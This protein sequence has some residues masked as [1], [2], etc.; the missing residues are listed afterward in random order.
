MDLAIAWA[1][2]PL[3]LTAV[4]AGCGLLVERLIRTKIPG[5]LIPVLGFATVIVV[6]QLVTL[7]DATARLATPV[8]VILAV[9][10][11]A[12]SWGWWRRLEP[13]AVAVA[14]GVFAAYAAPIVLSGQATFAGYIR[15][16][17]TATWMALTDRVMEH[18]RSLSGLA[19]STYEATLAFNLG[20][21][22]PVGAFLPLGIGRALVGQ[23]VAWLIQPYMAW[24]AGAASLALW[25]LASPVVRSRALR[26]LVSFL[27]ALSALLLGY[28]LW[29]GVKEVA[30]AALVA[31][32]AGLTGAAI[33]DR[34][35]VRALIPLALVSA[36]LIGVLS[37]G[38]G[39]WLAGLLV[40]ALPFAA[41]A[42]G[43]RRALGRATALVALIGLLCVPV[44]AP[45][46]FL[47]PT[48]A[49][50]SSETALGNLLHPLD[51][52]Q[53]FGIWPAGDFRLNPVNPGATYALIGATGVAALVGLYT[54]WRRRASTVLIYVGGALAACLAIILIGSPW[55]AGKAMATAS[56]AALMA[57][58]AG[59]AAL[60]TGGRGRTRLVGR[61]VGATLLAAIG[62]G[63]LWSGALAYRDLNLAPRNQLVELETIGHRIAGEGPTLMTEYQPYGVRHFLRDADPEGASELRRR[64]VPLLGGGTL[65]KGTSAD[66]DR[67][68]LSGLLV[69][70]TLVLRRSP[71]QSRPP[72]PY[73]LTWRGRYYEVWQRPEGLVS[74]VIDHLGLGTA[75][76]PTGE[77]KCSDVLRLAREAGP[78]GTL[79]AARRAAVEAVPLR[80]TSHPAA[81]RWAG[82]PATLLPVTPGTIRS[83]VR[84]SRPGR[85]EVWLGGSV[86]PRVDLLVDGRQ[87]GEVRHD[88]NNA[89]QFVLLGQTRLRAGAHELSI[90]F[91]GADLHPG[92]G[93]S[94]SPIGPLELSA[95]DPA[96]DRLTRVRAGRA[97]TLCGERLDW[98]EALAPGG[99]GGD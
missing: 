2:F 94:V 27:A 65:A 46:G 79:V 58:G 21:G 71:A 34:L 20:S 38:G 45:G 32:A 60:W 23:D 75:Q 47:P 35:S 68:R 16:D 77:P 73:R 17:D 9:A 28:Y 62:V 57:A 12:L 61:A 19:P 6:A 82:Y 66:T 36:A 56:P 5:A 26:S 8:A 86:R 51:A 88:L 93:G 97:T 22:Y 84:V 52:L 98:I 90:R 7:W 67:F 70:R 44:L 92:S 95:T 63:V 41:R 42:V 14:V 3:V 33:R 43:V 76:D 89:G 80:R 69:Y 50:L 1:L 72:S 40:A 78:S 29:G 91:H 48:S 31:A 99:L 30:G 74:S 37:G 81:W 10:G 25:E 49:S 4:C 18:G 96:Q 85:Y 64:Q 87:V 59:A 54:A 15:L 53:L 13:W 55:I 11:L 24:S 39:I 83:Q